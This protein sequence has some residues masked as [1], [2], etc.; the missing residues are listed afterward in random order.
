MQETFKG[1]AVITRNVTAPKPGAYLLIL[2]NGSIGPHALEQ[3]GVEDTD[4]EKSECLSKNLS[5]NVDQDFSRAKEAEIKI[6]GR[7]V[8]SLTSARSFLIVPVTLRGGTN[9]M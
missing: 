6:N 3:C 4:E 1:D 2:K 9:K 8:Q 5:E 7:W